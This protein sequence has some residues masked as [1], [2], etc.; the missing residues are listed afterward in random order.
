[1]ARSL[2]SACQRLSVG[3]RCPLVLAALF[4]QADKR[5]TCL[6]AAAH[7]DDV[8]DLFEIALMPPARVSHV[9]E[10]KQTNV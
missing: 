9:V 7:A 1:M 3:G 4:S 8:R 10:L 2:D 5:L 6:L